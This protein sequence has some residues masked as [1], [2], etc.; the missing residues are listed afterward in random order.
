VYM[1]RPARSYGEDDPMGPIVLV[2]F[3]RAIGKVRT[4]DSR[5]DNIV[6]SG[7]GDCSGESEIRS[8]WEAGK[9]EACQAGTCC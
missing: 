1:L 4:E 6:E 9:A 8:R 2:S 3:D 5:E 7:M